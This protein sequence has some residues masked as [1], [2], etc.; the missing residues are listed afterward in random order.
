[1]PY[2]SEMWD[3]MTTMRRDLERGN[4]LTKEDTADYLT[5]AGVPLDQ[6]DTLKRDWLKIAKKLGMT[7]SDTP[8]A[9]TMVWPAGVPGH[10]GGIP[11]VGFVHT[12]ASPLC[13]VAHYKWL[14]QWIVHQFCNVQHGEPGKSRWVALGW[15]RRPHGLKPLA[16]YWRARGHR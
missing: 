11:L 7:L 1:M 8:A 16:E 2:E 3:A 6:H 4:V 5:N 9:T 13:C 14:S 12:S 10:P 15:G